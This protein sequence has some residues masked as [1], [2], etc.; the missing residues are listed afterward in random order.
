MVNWLGLLL[1]IA[2]VTILVGSLATFSS[3]YRRRKAT[4]AASLSPWF[5][6]HLQRNIYLSLLH[7]EPSPEQ[8]KAPTVPDSVLKAAL[9]Q[10]ACEDIKR[11]LQVRNAKGP[12]SQLLQRGSVGDELWQRFLRAEKE[13]EAELRD[14]VEEA[15]AL[16]AGWG[17]V[18][19]QSANEMVNNATIRE[20]I[21]GVQA[22]GRKDREWWDQERASVQSQFMKELNDDAAGTEAPKVGPAAASDKVGSDEDTVLVEGGGPATPGS[23]A[24]KGPKKR[25]GKR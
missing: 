6:P 8:E 12:L 17:Q 18:I 15:N 7:L 3:L 10:R 13:V 16:Q 19:F 21:V 20:K 23:T 11:V 2:Y 14:V 1:P 22:K 5:P 24:G 9:L 25:K 4:S